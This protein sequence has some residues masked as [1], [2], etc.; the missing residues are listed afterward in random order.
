MLRL[1]VP[2]DLDEIRRLYRET[3]LNVNIRD[4]DQ[5]QVNAWAGRWT[6]LPGWND[7]MANQYFLVDD[8]DGKITGFTSLTKEGHVDLLFVHHASFYLKFWK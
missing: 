7:R 2:D 3:I 8:A 5:R 6:N 1:A 4:Y